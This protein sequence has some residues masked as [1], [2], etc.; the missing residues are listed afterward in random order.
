MQM[1]VSEMSY[2][3]TGNRLIGTLRFWFN[4]FILNEPAL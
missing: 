1:S 3:I 2:E 4:V